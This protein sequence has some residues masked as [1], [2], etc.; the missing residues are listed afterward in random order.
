MDLLI[1]DD[2]D[3]VRET[4]AA[5]LLA[6]G[7]SSVQTVASL[8]DA[9]ASLATTR[10]DLVLLDYAMPGMRGLAG[11]A[12]ALVAAGGRPV[13]I[14]SGTISRDLAEAALKAGAAGF[15]PK[16]L[17]SRAIAAAIRHMA[18]GEI[19]APIGLLSGEAPVTGD[20]STLT[21]REIDVL[22]G[23]C[24]GLSNKEI[25]RDL[26]LQEVTVKLHVKTLSRKLDA[27]NRTHAAMIAR[28]AGLN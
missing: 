28:S 13:A 10:F 26:D 16:T 9:L 15:V 3:L 2:H 27:R 14:I 11:L 24:R 21:R 18:S 25:A 23:L 4:L 6:E 22:R 7:F 5:F 1:A 19:F 8:D 20:L 17:G 12:E